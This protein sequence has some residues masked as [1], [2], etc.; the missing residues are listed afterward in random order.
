MKIGFVGLGRM[1]AAIAA[2]VLRAGHELVV[3]NRTPAKAAG[4]AEGGARMAA[5]PAAVGREAE[6]VLTMLAD[7][8]GLE[9]VL[10][11]EEGL[12]AGLAPGGL[13][14]S[15]STISVAAGDAAADQHAARGQHYLSAPVFGRPEAAAAAALFVVAAGEAAQIDRVQ[16]VLDAIGRRTFRVGDRPSQAN[17]VKLAGN[18][19]MLSAIEA[20]SEAMAL[21]EKGGIPPAQLLEVMTGTLF[22]ALVYRNYGAIL[23]EQRFHPA[24]FTVPLG[25]KDMK[26]VGAAA[27]A[28]RVPM[29]LLA[30]LREHL[31]ETMAK[32]G[33][34][35]DWSAIGLTAAKNAGLK[36]D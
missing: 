32:E 24:G 22:D 10:E 15:L 14:V 30:L 28:S 4:L 25:L 2:N 35:I 18:F 36:R 7:D 5:S 31:I 20:M 29:P 17:L 21:A 1:G 8:A 12:L 34:E 16:P 27:E 19:M 26:L 23:A 33:E 13:H 6:I 11:G 3:W 9:A